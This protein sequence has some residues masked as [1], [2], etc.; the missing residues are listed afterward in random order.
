[1]NETLTLRLTTDERDVL[2]HA[3]QVA[4]TR[5]PEGGDREDFTR[6]ENR[7]LDMSA[8]HVVGLDAPTLE[9][10]PAGRFR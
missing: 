8:A 3:L 5:T 6:L 10:D 7:V 2:L 1:M 9:N 4:I